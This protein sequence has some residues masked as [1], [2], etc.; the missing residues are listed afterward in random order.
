M[1]GSTYGASA[2]LE[3][4]F[5]LGSSCT[6]ACMCMSMST[7]LLDAMISPYRPLGLG[8]FLVGCLWRLGGALPA[9]GWP[10]LTLS[11]AKSVK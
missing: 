8:Q 6:A 1:L 11:D 3:L 7:S 5:L 10:W 9:T 4:P 2:A